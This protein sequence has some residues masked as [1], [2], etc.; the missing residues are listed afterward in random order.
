METPRRGLSQQ[1]EVQTVE[2]NVDVNLNSSELEAQDCEPF[3]WTLS[4]PTRWCTDALARCP[5]ESD[6]AIRA[7]FAGKDVASSIF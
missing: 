5:R 1:S 4:W 3:G 2:E 7:A 6:A